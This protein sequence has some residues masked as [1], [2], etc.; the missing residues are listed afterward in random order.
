M[1]Q[2]TINNESKCKALNF[3]LAIKMAEMNVESGGKNRFTYP[4]EMIL[5]L[6]RIRM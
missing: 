5:G 4:R 2:Q 6:N 1:N 3:V